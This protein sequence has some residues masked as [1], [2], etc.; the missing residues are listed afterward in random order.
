MRIKLWKGK[1]SHNTSDNIIEKETKREQAPRKREKR[2][3]S[4]ELKRKRD[5]GR[6]DRK[7]RKR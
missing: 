7:L 5:R 4:E 1:F 2:R 3:K 6:K